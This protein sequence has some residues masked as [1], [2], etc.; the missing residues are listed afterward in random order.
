MVMKGKQLK[1]EWM[2]KMRFSNIYLFTLGV[3]FFVLGAFIE[4]ETI[5]SINRINAKPLD[6]PEH[7]HL[8]FFFV[9]FLALCSVYFSEK[10]E[11]TILSSA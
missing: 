3:M 9:G 2:R 1:V 6:Y 5:A 10:I 4:W 7:L 8:I 11:S